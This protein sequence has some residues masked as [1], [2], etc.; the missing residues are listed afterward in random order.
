MILC[1]ENISEVMVSSTKKRPGDSPLW[2]DMQKIKDIFLAGRR[3][4]VGDG[5]MISFWQDA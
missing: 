2:T 3:M 5:R 1:A 4:Q